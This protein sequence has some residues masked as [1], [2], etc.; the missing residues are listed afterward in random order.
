MC[1]QTKGKF[2]T[3]YMTLI[4]TTLYLFKPVLTLLRVTYVVFGDLFYF[5]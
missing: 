2:I 3:H 4:P 5:Y 1:I